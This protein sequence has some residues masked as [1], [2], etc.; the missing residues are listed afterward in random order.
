MPE[1]TADLQGG[2]YRQTN[3]EAFLRQVAEGTGLVSNLLWEDR[4]E[5]LHFQS[6]RTGSASS[7]P[8]LS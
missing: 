2:H 8:S 4:H 5:N 3:R 7:R 1:R 6:V